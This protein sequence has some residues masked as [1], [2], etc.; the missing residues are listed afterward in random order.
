MYIL[1]ENGMKYNKIK[2]AVLSVRRIMY[3]EDMHLSD[4]KESKNEI[5]F[6]ECKWDQS[7]HYKGF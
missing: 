1:P 7:L 3:N 2:K 6:L 5:Y 4:L